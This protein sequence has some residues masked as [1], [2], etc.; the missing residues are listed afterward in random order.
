MNPALWISKT[1]LD[2]QTKDL[3]RGDL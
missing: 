2:A 1:E 3:L